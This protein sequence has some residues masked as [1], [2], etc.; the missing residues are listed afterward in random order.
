V[1]YVILYI[2]I[3]VLIEKAISIYDGG[4]TYLWEY[5]VSAII[6]PLMII[7]CI[8]LRCVVND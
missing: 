1:G 3:G 4:T 7:L 6:W 8:F 5:A 2:L